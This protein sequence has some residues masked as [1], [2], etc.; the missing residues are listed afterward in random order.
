[1]RTALLAGA[2]GLVGGHLLARLL[3]DGT[4]DRVVSIGRREVDVR[5]DRLEQLV[6]QLP[7]VPALPAVDDAFCALGTTIKQAGSQ[8]AFRAVDHDA[9]V[10][11][12]AAGQQAGARSFLH[13]TAM[14]A[15]ARSRLFYNRVK[16]E[17]E[18][19]V[20]ALG[21]PTT[22][23]FRPSIIDGDRAE[24]RRGEQLSLSVMRVS[25]PVL[26]PFRPTRAE[27]IAS[28]MVQQA[29]AAPAGTTVVSA[30]EI[31][32]RAS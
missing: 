2:T 20:A 1:M 12:A 31:T 17:T 9:V 5:H 16:G 4:W 7:D 25:A 24:A 30:R 27:D 3:E 19:D 8:D 29:K 21:I 28:A 18:R 26:G 10:A 13:V 14:G 23:A 11:L 6:T 22:V 32:K 15:N